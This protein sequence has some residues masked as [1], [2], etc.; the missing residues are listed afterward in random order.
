GYLEEFEV[1][2]NAIYCLKTG[3][4]FMFYCIKNNPNKIKSLEG[5]DLV[6][7][8]EAEKVSNERWDILIPTI[9]KERS[10]I[11]VTF[12]PKNILDPTYQRFVIAP[13]K[14]SFVRKINYDENPYFPETLRLEMEECKERDYE[15]YR[16]IWLG[17]PVA[18][19]DKVIIK[20]V[21]IE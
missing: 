6:W 5:I 8:E 3:S 15:L 19:S 17:E 11:W 10:E 12:N 4:D 20:P 13:P 9:R 14:N 1:Q 21:W 16:H 18:D 2:R 7:I